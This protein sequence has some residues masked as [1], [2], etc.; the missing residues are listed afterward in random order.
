MTTELFPR[1]LDTLIQAIGCPDTRSAFTRMLAAKRRITQDMAEIRAMRD[2]LA[3]VVEL[4]IDPSRRDMAETVLKQYNDFID[5]V[6]SIF[7]AAV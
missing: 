2:D 5:F 6:D 1:A 7:P 4:Q 3:K